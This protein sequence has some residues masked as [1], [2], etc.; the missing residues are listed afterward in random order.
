MAILMKNT[1]TRFQ[2]KKDS[3]SHNF[4]E[5]S[6]LIFFITI[7]LMIFF[8]IRLIKLLTSTVYMMERSSKILPLTYL[9][10]F[11]Y[12]REIRNIL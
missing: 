12:I 9:H 1:N 5:Y 2:F 11:K 4:P 6:K 10:K 7:P 8:L 3:L